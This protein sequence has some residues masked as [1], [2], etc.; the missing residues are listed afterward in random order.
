MYIIVNEVS[1]QVWYRILLVY[2]KFYKKQYVSLIFEERKR[3]QHFISFSRPYAVQYG[4]VSKSS[5][6]IVVVIIYVPVFDVCVG[7]NHT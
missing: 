2:Q 4:N 3:L 1:I 5:D 6:K 7:S